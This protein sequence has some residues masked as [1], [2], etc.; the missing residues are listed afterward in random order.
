M[1]AMQRTGGAPTVNRPQLIAWIEDG[2]VGPSSRRLYLTLLGVCGKP[3]DVG[4]VFDA[5]GVW[6]ST[7]PRRPGGK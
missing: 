2:S 7:F 6:A 4:S 1:S 5:G 3:E